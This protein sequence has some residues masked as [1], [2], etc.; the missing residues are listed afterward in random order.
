M[1]ALE[2][3]LTFSG[4]AQYNVISGFANDIV[5]DCLSVSVDARNEATGI[6]SI[7]DLEVLEAMRSFHA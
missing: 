2:K 3:S 7:H 6:T 5:H 4:I 1:S